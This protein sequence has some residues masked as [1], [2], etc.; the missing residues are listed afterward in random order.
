[1]PEKSTSPQTVRASAALEASGAWDASPSS[2]SLSPTT[3]AVTLWC[4]YARAG[5]GGYAALRPQISPDGVTW[6]A[7]PLVDGTL[8]TTAP[9]GSL[10][11]VAAQ[12]RLPA[13]A[14]TDPLGVALL[15]DVSGA[16]FLRVAAAEVGAAST[17][18]TLAVTLSENAS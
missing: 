18:G 1:M 17:P 5:S 3:Q 2:V 4:L 16:R 14:D 10:P 9:Y 6:Y 11:I 8:T 12:Y 15:L 7:A 13:P